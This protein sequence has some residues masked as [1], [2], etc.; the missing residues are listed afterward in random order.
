M[1]GKGCSGKDEDAYLTVLL[2]RGHLKGWLVRY[3]VPSELFLWYPCF[4]FR[5][6]EDET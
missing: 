5:Y 3:S 2:S 6:E 1:R 4:S